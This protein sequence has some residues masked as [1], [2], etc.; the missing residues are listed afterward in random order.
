M[1]RALMEKHL[2]LAEE[3]VIKGARIVARQR[4]LVQELERDGHNTMKARQTLA[5][6]EELQELHIAE[7][8]RL[9]RELG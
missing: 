9:R 2:E 1:D 5:Q 7:R 3:H 6:F 8:D 4:E